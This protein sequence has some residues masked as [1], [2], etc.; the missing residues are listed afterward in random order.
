MWTVSY[1]ERLEEWLQ[2][3]PSDIKARVLR[4]VDMLVQFG[5]GNA[6]E[7]YVRPVKGYKKLF[8]IR[9]KG[10]DG[11]ARVFITLGNRQATKLMT[12]PDVSQERLA[13]AAQLA[14][15]SDETPE[16]R[17]LSCWQKKSTTSA[18][19]TGRHSCGLF[20]SLRRPA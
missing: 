17:R 1:D 16:G 3:I 20:H 2:E 19:A 15:L 9:A 4:I 18:G 11:I 14:S 5:P 6:R 12:A 8:E 13:N 10:K 7:P